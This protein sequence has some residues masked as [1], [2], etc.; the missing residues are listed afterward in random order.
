MRLKIELI[1]TDL[2][3]NFSGLRGTDVERSQ[4]IAIETAIMRR[5]G[6]IKCGQQ[7]IDGQGRFNYTITRPNSSVHTETKIRAMMR[8]FGLH[9]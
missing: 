5:C 7:A 3:L 1:G 9:V 4:L 8:E 6:S 2:Q